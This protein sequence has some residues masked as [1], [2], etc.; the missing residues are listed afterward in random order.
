MNLL[1]AFFFAALS[2]AAFAV[3]FRAPSKAVAPIGVIAG[4]GYLIF[5]LLKQDASANILAF[6]SSALAL[7]CL[8]EV[9]ARIF[10]YPATLFLVP[11]LLPIVP[12][13]QLY[14]TML[15]FVEGSVMEAISQG[16]S[17]LLSA[18][19]I[20]MAVAL[21]ALVMFPLVRIGQRKGAKQG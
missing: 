7:A 18:G 17:T 15:L 5:E 6:F 20:A 4:V 19:A 12:G 11:G 14:Q 10:K 13:V 21:S 8:S 9:A 16:A 2:S 3:L 1:L